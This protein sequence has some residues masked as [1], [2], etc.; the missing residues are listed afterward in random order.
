MSASNSTL[1]LIS[2]CAQS[3]QYQ[4]QMNL[5]PVDP[6]LGIKYIITS[7]TRGHSLDGYVG[8]ILFVIL[9]I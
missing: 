2:G 3:G 1:S 5:P 9:Q 8:A 6:S 7:I 4:A